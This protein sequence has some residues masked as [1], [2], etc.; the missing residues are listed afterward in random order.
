MRVPKIDHIRAIRRFGAFAVTLRA[1]DKRRMDRPEGGR[2]LRADGPD[3]GSARLVTMILGLV[4]MLI[5][6]APDG[7]ERGAPGGKAING[8]RQVA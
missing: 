7:Q 6:S 4:D 2:A 1:S 8:Y 5:S 3:P